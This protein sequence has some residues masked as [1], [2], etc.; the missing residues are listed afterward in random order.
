ML[1][2]ICKYPYYRWFTQ[3]EAYQGHEKDPMTNTTV[4]DWCKTYPDHWEIK[5]T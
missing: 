2:F 1:V 4:E 5:I 3:G